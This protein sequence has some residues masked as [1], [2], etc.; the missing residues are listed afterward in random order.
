MKRILL[1]NIFAACLVGPFAA[2]AVAQNPSGTSIAVIDVPKV[3]KNHDLFKQYM[4][5][6]AADDKAFDALLRQKKEEVTKMVE[7]AKDFD[8]GSTE[9]RAIEEKVARFQSQVQVETQL[10]RKEFMEREAKAYYQAY[11]EIE[12]HVKSFADHNGISLVLRFDGEELDVTKRETIMQGI[13][14]N[15]VFQ[16]QLDI[17]DFVLAQLNPPPA[18]A[19][20]GSGPFIP[21]R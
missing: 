17:T 21:R 12:Y 19:N 16:R 7:Q 18:P 13:N 5:L 3:F 8:A 14:R 4:E 15:V 20:I 2:N 9:Y 11:K 6:I 10:K 1:Y